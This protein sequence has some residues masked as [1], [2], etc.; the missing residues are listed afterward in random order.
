MRTTK[1]TAGII[2]SSGPQGYNISSGCCGGYSN[3]LD[4]S[5]ESGARIPGCLGVGR[6]ECSKPPPRIADHA[7]NCVVYI[8]IEYNIIVV[9]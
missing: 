2:I 3:Q 4:S 8:I 7:L 9:H 6:S 1:F 5:S